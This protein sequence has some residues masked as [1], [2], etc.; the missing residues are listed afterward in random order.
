MQSRV[1]APLLLALGIGVSAT[2]AGLGARSSTA[3]QSHRQPV[4]AQPST[5]PAHRA[6]LLQLMRGTLFLHSNVVFASQGKNPADAPQAKNPS[7]STDPLTGTYGKWES[8]ENS[9]L[10]I[11]ETADLLSLPGRLCS[12][13]QP[14]PTTHSD[15]SGLVNGLREAGWRSYEA[16]RS[17]DQDKMADAAE[18][19]TNAC[20]K[21]HVKYRDHDKLEDR[22]R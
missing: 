16:A 22:C 2:S 9:S 6:N 5:G 18:T 1:L 14:V 20:S 12:N 17:R 8:V 3:A 15:W 13:G 11:V 19:L 10:A 7:A 21:C 4:P